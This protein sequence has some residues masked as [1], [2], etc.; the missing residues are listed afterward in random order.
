MTHDARLPNFE[1]TTNEESQK[2]ESRKKSLRDQ[3]CV[4]SE[5]RMIQRSSKAKGAWLSTSS[6]ALL[7]LVMIGTSVRATITLLVVIH[8]SLRETCRSRPSG[9]PRA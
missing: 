3:R 7:P 4:R 8:M 9:V 2:E 6:R 1:M 5:T